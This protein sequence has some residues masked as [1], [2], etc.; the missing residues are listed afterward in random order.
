MLNCVPQAKCCGSLEKRENLWAR[1]QPGRLDGGASRWLLTNGWV[2]EVKGQEREESQR[3]G[4]QEVRSEGCRWGQEG[5]VASDA[6]WEAR[7][8]LLHEGQEAQPEMTQQ[9]QCFNPGHRRKKWH[10]LNVLV[11]K[12]CQVLFFISTTVFWIEEIVIKLQNKHR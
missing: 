10:F 11:S 3:L 6:L 1:A 5:G 8:K 2:G 12:E 4:T 7:R 9:Q